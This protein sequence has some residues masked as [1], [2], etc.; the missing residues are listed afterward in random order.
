MTAPVAPPESA[1]V[2]VADRFPVTATAPDG[3]VHRLA[4]VIVTRP[5]PA[6]PGWVWI[7]GNRRPPELLWSGPW[8]DTD[9]DQVRVVWA[10]TVSG[11]GWSFVKAR[12]CGCAAGALKRMRPWEPMRR[13]QL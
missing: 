13:G 12:G 2:V 7:W 6:H 3:A 10:L 5:T 11:G 1:R 4:R 9:L 8:V